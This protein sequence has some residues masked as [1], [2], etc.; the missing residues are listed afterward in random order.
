MAESTEQQ[1]A[2]HL[3]V[4]GRVR[5]LVPLLDD[6]A[7][8]LIRVY[9]SGGR[10]FTFGNGGSAADAQH[11]AAE[12]VG[13]YKR[14][15]RPLPA[16]ALSVDPSVVSCIGNDYGFDDVFARQ[17]EAFAGPS[18]MVIGFTTSGR[19]PN[20][21]GGLEAARKQG[22]TAVLFTGSDGGPAA[23]HAD[24]ALVVPSSTT[25]RIQEMHL[26]LLHLLSERVDVWAAGEGTDD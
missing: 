12:L 5:E 19:S 25:A 17:V 22:A 23:A 11:L 18:D 26:M 10:L 8:R 24:V 4:A 3:E 15:R 2:E 14:D 9:E 1:L 13:R 6:V 16:A 7:A 20:V 21:V